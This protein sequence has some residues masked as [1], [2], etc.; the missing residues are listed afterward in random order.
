[1]ILEK[2][3]LWGEDWR[4][5]ITDRPSYVLLIALVKCLW[6]IYPI[7]RNTDVSILCDNFWKRM[8]SFPKAASL[9]CYLYCLFEVAYRGGGV[10]VST[11]PPSRFQRPSKIV[12]NWTW[13][14]KP[15]KIAEFR[16]PTPQDVCK[17]GSTVLKQPPVRDCF[18]LSMTNKLVVIVNSLKVPKIKK[19]LLY[20]MKFL[21]RNYSCLQNPRLGG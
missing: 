18:T 11:P 19:I 3:R 20:E 15:L 1:M 10:G 9:L 17:K 8:Y 14:W 4:I 6:K 12:P 2:S 7:W 21:A 16:T 5:E 13:L